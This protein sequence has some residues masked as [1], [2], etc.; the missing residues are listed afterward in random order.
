MYFYLSAVGASAPRLT[1]IPIDIGTEMPPIT[2]LWDTGACISAVKPLRNPAP[3]VFQNARLSVAAKGDS[4]GIE[5][6]C[7]SARHALGLLGTLSTK[8]V[9]HTVDILY[10]Q[11]ICDVV[12]AS[13]LRGA[14]LSR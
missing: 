11:Y 9:Y 4:W 12:H 10:L 5:K 2:D 8:Q 3:G 1:K 13:C 7:R 6:R 14:E